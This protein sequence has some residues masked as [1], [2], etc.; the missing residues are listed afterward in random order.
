MKKLAIGVLF[1]PLLFLS[2]CSNNLALKNETVTP[3]VQPDVSQNP[4]VACTEEAKVC[5]DGTAVGRSGPNCEFA[6]CSAA[7]TSTPVAT[8][9]VITY[10]NNQ[11]GFTLYLP[12]TWE[13]YT[14]SS[15]AIEYGEKVAISFPGSSV[16]NPHEVIPILVYPLATWQKWEKTNFEGYPT[17]APIGP[18]ERG[19]NNVYV[20]ATAPRYNFDFQPGFE[21]VEKII[22]AL[23]TTNLAK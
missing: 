12:K 4:Q 8:S 1:F 17:A 21:E 18:Q 3:I 22:L 15:T 11:Y 7:A 16:K 19:R 23:Q 14:S 9:T 13:G 2:A 20:I 6:P 5:P 10:Q